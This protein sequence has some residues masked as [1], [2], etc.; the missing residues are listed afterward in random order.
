MRKLFKTAAEIDGS[1]RAAGVRAADAMVLAA[2][3][4]PYIWLETA[5]VDDEAEI[6]LGATKI[7]G[8]PDL[9][10]TMPWPWR[11][12]YPDHEQRVEEMQA[13]VA[14]FNPQ[15]MMAEQA[16]MLEEFRKLLPRDEFE[17]FAAES[18]KV[19]YSKFSLDSLVEDIM[20]LARYSAWRNVLSKFAAN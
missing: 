17:A 14:L 15:D 16:E 1:L 18:A 20:R 2:R 10:V 3:S 6:V 9:P 7:G 11:P 4:K 5:P 13:G 19:D 12:R 8:T